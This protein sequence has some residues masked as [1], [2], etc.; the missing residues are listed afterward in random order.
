MDNAILFGFCYYI[1][2]F[3]IPFIIPGVI[4]AIYYIYKSLKEKK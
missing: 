4:V 3:F 1:L 2:P